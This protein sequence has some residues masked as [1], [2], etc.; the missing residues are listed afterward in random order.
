MSA[1]AVSAYKVCDYSEFTLP[2]LCCPSTASGPKLTLATEA[3]AAVQL[4]LTDHM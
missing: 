2:A 4:T 1:N 3:V